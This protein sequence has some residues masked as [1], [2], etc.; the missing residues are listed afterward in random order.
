MVGTV[1]GDRFAND[2]AMTNLTKSLH[3]IVL[4]RSMLWPTTQHGMFTNLIIIAHAREAFYHSMGGNS[5]SV[6]KLH[7]IFNDGKR[8][9]DII[10]PQLGFTGN[11]RA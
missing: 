2:I 11:N 1:N 10:F 7:I 9:N 8:S 4:K 5:I 6:T 3:T